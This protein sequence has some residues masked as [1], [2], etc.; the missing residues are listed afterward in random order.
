VK[1]KAPA[2]WIAKQQAAIEEGFEAQKPKFAPPPSPDGVSPQVK[3][4]SN[5]K[6]KQPE[7][8]PEIIKPEPIKPKSQTPL[9]V[10]ANAV[11]QLKQTTS[12]WKSKQVQEEPETTEYEHK[13][14]TTPPLEERATTLAEKKRYFN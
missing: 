3:S 12:N 14:I 5:F 2:N 9:V 4:T 11:S 7:P 1:Q 8:E 6:S 13:P 10:P